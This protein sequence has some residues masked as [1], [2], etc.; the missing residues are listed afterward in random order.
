[1]STPVEFPASFVRPWLELLRSHQSE[2]QQDFPNRHVAHPESLITTSIPKSL[3]LGTGLSIFTRAILPAIL[4]AT[5]SVHFVTC[6]W[7]AS[8]TL[9]ALRETLWQ[10]A[11]SRK[12][13]TAGAPKLRITIGFSS[14]G[15]LQKLFHTSSRAGHIYPPAQWRKLGLP[16]ESSLRDG[17]IELTV[18]SLF[19]TPLSVIHPK[20]VIVDEAR[21]FVPSCNVSWERW[22]EGC[23]ELEGEAVSTMLSLH[24]AVWEIGSRSRSLPNAN[25]NNNAATGG[26]FQSRH[27]ATEGDGEVLESITS[28][29]ALSDGPYGRGLSTTQSIKIAFPHPVPTIFLPSSHHRNPRFTFFPFLSRSRP[30]MTPLNGALLTLFANAQSDIAILT[31][32]M[33]S[34]PVLDALL[35]ALDRGVNVQIRTSKNM[36]LIEQ[37]ITAGTTTSRCLGH[38]VKKYRQRQ[39]QRQRSDLEAQA[40]SLGRL[41]ILYYKPLDGRGDEPVFSHFKMTSVDH[42]YLVLGSGNM[43]RASWWTSQELGVLLYVPG[44]A[45]SK[46]CDSVLNMRTELYFTSAGY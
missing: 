41:E 26:N 38:L 43:D 29:T 45:A 15:L 17:G 23:I 35:D 37:L 27:S 4:S 6:Y 13:R 12:H 3:D 16:D 42:D 21:A 14:S 34:W 33:T 2:Q 46:M 22:F 39:R 5:H 20:Y 1:M 36:M 30:P 18:K 8:P 7:A 19:F 31:P 44:F 10:L 11:S 32:N 24:A 9:D 28:C 25:I 40:A